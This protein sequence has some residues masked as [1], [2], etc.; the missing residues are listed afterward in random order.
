M[1]IN[2]KAPL[3]STGLNIVLALHTYVSCR[4]IEKGQTRTFYPDILELTNSLHVVTKYNKV[5]EKLKQISK[6]NFSSCNKT[7]LK[8]KKI[9]KWQF[10]QALISNHL[11]SKYWLCYCLQVQ[12]PPV[13]KQTKRFTNSVYNANWLLRAQTYRYF[14]FST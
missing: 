10:F 6:H 5:L 14:S 4:R 11:K 1:E 3:K 9:K 13:L 7:Y 2:V 12:V 8:Q